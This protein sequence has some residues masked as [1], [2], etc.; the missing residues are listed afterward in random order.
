M[1]K[2]KISNKQ[3]DS[4][5]DGFQKH[6][7]EALIK[8]GTLKRYDPNTDLLDGNLI[9]NALWQCLCEGDT[10]S[11]MEILEAHLEAKNKSKLCRESG[12]SR[13]TLYNTL[14]DRNPR[15]STLAKL[16]QYIH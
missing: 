16:I 2:A 9:A 14:R 8:D 3:E 5:R 4:T 13:T 15:L 11:F 7:L 1:G 6:R 10:E 12:I